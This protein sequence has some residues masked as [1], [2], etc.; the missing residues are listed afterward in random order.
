MMAQV[1]AP[2]ARAAASQVAAG[3]HT[4]RTSRCAQ[5]QRFIVQNASGGSF[6]GNRF[7]QRVRRAQQWRAQQQACRPQSFCGPQFG[8]GGP[9]LGF[10]MGVSPADVQNMMKDFEKWMGNVDTG[11]TAA[12][13]PMFVPVDIDQDA[14][15]YTFTADLPG[16]SKAD[17]KVQANK[18]DRMLTISGT[19]AAPEMSEDQKQRR[20]RTERRFGKFR[21]SF[22]LPEDAD[23]SGITARFRDGVLT[24][25]IKRTKPAEP[26]TTDVPIDDWFDV[27]PESGEQA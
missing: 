21:R 26:E 27:R 5:P 12:G 16:V 9:G 17:T 14:D 20:R 8:M 3:R 6:G 24:V 10:G 19:R 1:M 11:S 15:M 7:Q 13:M 25:M 2:A 4:A 23:L 22:Q 18:D